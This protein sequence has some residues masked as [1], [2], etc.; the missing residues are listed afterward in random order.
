MDLFLP[1]PPATSAASTSYEFMG[2]VH[3]RID[4]FRRKLK[5]GEAKGDDPIA[6]VATD[7]AAEIRLL[8]FDEFAVNDI[9][10]AMILGRLFEQLFARGLTVVATSNVA[11]AS[12]TRTGSTARSSC[13]SSSFSKGAWASSIS[14]RRATIA[15]TTPMQ[16]PVT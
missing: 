5:S 13:P 3:D 2:E 12:S 15:S 9:A 16:D 8:C 14:T 7:I 4:R 10:D 1:S 11:P 6:P